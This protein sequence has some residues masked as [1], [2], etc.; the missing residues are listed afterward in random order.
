MAKESPYFRFYPAEWFAGDITMQEMEHRGVFIEL[1]AY[2]WQK[3]CDLTLAKAKQRFS[4]YQA[5]V[6]L[7]LESG[8]FTVNAQMLTI[9]FLDEQY[10]RALELSQ[11][12]SKQG[13]LG[14][15]AK[16]KQKPSKSQATAIYK[17]KDKDKDNIYANVLSKINSLSGKNQVQIFSFTMRMPRPV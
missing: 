12:R 17:D 3:D 9:A 11:K 4:K 10:E 16:A 13:R 15:V 2:Y 7:L 5:S 6:D 1:C 14:G 8:I